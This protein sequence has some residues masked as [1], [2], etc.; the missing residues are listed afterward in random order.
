MPTT[1]V[2]DKASA[3]SE[4]WRCAD[5]TEPRPRRA[6]AGAK[7][8]VDSYCERNLGPNGEANFIQN[9]AS[10][11]AVLN[12]SCSNSQAGRAAAPRILSHSCCNTN[13]SEHPV[14]LH[15][16]ISREAFNFFFF[17]CIHLYIFSNVTVQATYMARYK[18]KN[19]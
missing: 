11:P 5:G 1:R 18:K 6:H 2:L 19:D 17:K 9:S 14:S 12:L 4:R 8:P 10:L 15:A 7:T 16:I 3:R 13:C